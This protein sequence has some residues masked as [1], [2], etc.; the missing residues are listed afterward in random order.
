[1]FLAYL[2]VFT[3]YV[4]HDEYWF[5]LR[6]E[7]QFVWNPMSFSSLLKGRPGSSLLFTLHGLLV[8]DIFDLIWLRMIA[9]GQVVLAA[10]LCLPWW[11][12]MTGRRDHSILLSILIFTLPPFMVQISWMGCCPHPTAVLLA[13][14]A[15]NFA[16]RIVGQGVRSFLSINALT[17][18]A[19][20]LA[21]NLIYPSA[22]VFYWVLVFVLLIEAYQRHLWQC[23][24][25]IFIPVGIGLFVYGVYAGIL[26]TIGWYAGIHGFSGLLPSIYDPQAGTLDLVQRLS[27]FFQEPLLNALNL[28]KIFPGSI[29]PAVL[30]FL[31]T[32]AAGRYII[33]A[34]DER[35][36]RAPHAA[37]FLVLSLAVVILMLLSFLPNLAAPAEIAFYR[38]LVGLSPLILLAV[39]LLLKNNWIIKKRAFLLTGFLILFVAMVIPLVCVNLFFY[40]TLPSLTETMYLSSLLDVRPFS[41]SE[42]IHYQ[43][44]LPDDRGARYDEFGTYSLNFSDDVIQIAICHYRESM[45]RKIYAGIQFS[46]QCQ[47]E[48]CRWLTGYWLN[49]SR[50]HLFEK[51]ILLTEGGPV[52]PT[53][54]PTTVL[55]A[56][57]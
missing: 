28:W 37:S 52:P 30:T 38:C 8:N 2:P 26:K 41:V 42:H 57:F 46:D 16:A 44:I 14:A 39:Y 33:I 6:P 10:Y 4:Y 20:F 5:F 19:L 3:P 17:A 11:D 47:W 49:Q 45:P 25:D 22:A 55:S 40:R 21:A 23:A 27:W 24:Q 32:A 36:G 31:L 12:R 48:D 54:I 1:M 51:S 34:S 43:K 15:A 35:R 29:L 53:R 13:I 9:W 18:G 50:E 56:P 7:G